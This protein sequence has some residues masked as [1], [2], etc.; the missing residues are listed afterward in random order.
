M[1]EPKGSKPWRDP[2]MVNYGGA[3]TIVSSLAT[4]RGLCAKGRLCFR[5]VDHGGNCYPADPE[6]EDNGG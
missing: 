1:P 2:A 5:K 3:R 4:T 6:K